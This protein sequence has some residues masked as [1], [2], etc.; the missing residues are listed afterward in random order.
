MDDA[1]SETIETIVLS[2]TIQGV[3]VYRTTNKNRTTNHQ[4][5]R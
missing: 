5:K 2:L 3:N 4:Y 1:A